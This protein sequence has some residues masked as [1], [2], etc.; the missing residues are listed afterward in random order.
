[1][2]GH[3][4]WTSSARQVGCKISF[5]LLEQIGVL[6][7]FCLLEV[8]D[9]SK[10]APDTVTFKNCFKIRK[11]DDDKDTTPVPHSFNF[12]ARQDLPN[13]GLGMDKV[14]RIPRA[15]RNPAESHRDIFALVKSRMASTSLAQDPLLC[16]PGS[17]QA[18]AEE[19]I[20]LANREDCPKQSWK[21]EDE[22]RQEL[23]L[24]C[25]AIKRD[26]PHMHRACAWYASMD[27]A[28]NPAPVPDLAFLRSAPSIEPNLHEFR[29][30]ERQ[31]ELCPHALQVAFRRQG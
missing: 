6:Q 26:Y 17:L 20:K 13:Q 5:Q 27:D 28:A 23:S 14:E 7:S 21:I 2:D 11:Q 1:M 18:K 31:P 19:F 16:M 15:M 10:M 12:M 3:L 9:W 4:E 24:L 8:R 22:R 25:K 29:L 30:G